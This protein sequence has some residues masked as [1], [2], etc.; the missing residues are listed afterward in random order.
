MK[1]KNIRHFY[2]DEM[3]FNDNL[4]NLGYNFERNIL[5][6]VVSKEMFANPINDIPLRQL[7][8]I[9]EFLVNQVK[10]IKLEYNYTLPKDAT[11]LN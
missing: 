1:L 4:T 10:R 8:R 5:K 9:F 11:N 3:H 7:E 2:E 6:N